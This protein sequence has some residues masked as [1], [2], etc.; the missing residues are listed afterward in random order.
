MATVLIGWLLIFDFPAG[1]DREIGAFLALIAAIT[2]AAGAGD[3]RP[4]R[5]ALVEPPRSVATSPAQCGRFE[6]RGSG[7][8]AATP[9]GNTFGTPAPL[10]RHR[11][12]IAAR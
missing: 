9:S 12:L 11:S 2:I 5:G 1:A 4:L 10:V 3:Y 6:E 7:L 8:D